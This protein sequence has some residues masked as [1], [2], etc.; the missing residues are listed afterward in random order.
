MK[1]KKTK[2]IQDGVTMQDTVAELAKGSEGKRT[3]LPPKERLALYKN[4]IQ[5]A[6]TPTLEGMTKWG[7]ETEVHV[8][9][10]DL[11][12][13]WE[14]YITHFSPVFKGTSDVAYGLVKAIETEPGYIPLSDLLAFPDMIVDTNFQPVTVGQCLGLVNTPGSNPHSGA[15]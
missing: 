5:Q 14:W 6:G 9:F 11:A 8:K 1:H 12:T 13:G 4:A 3:K 2:A 10:R 15:Q 7:V